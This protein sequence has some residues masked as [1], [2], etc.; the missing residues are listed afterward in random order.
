M[1]V[2]E[3]VPT[4][5]VVWMPAYK[6]KQSAGKARCG[7]GELL[8]ANDI[9]GNA[10]ADRL[11][12]LAV[13]QHRVDAVEVELWPRLCKQTTATAMW[14]ARATWA[15][16]NCEEAPFRDTEASQWRADLSR[17]ELRAKK[18]AAAAELALKPLAKGPPDLRGHDPVQMLQLSG[19]RSGWRCSICKKNSSSKKFWFEISVLVARWADGA[20]F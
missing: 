13:E 20:R 9:A 12:K 8:T 4:D 6:S 17:K 15:A 5:K 19:I 14:I 11:A 1:S 2:L 18:A 10:E 16:S 7:N 3:E